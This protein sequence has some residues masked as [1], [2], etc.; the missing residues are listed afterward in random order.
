[1]YRRN[2]YFQKVYPRASRPPSLPRNMTIWNVLVR[3]CCQNAQRLFPGRPIFFLLFFL[4]FSAIKYTVRPQKIPHF[5]ILDSSDEHDVQFALEI[6]SRRSLS[7]F[8]NRRNRIL[9]FSD[10]CFRRIHKILKNGLSM[11]PIGNFGVR[12]KTRCPCVKPP[13]CWTFEFIRIVVI[14][15]NSPHSLLLNFFGFRPQ[16]HDQWLSEKVY[17]VVP[18]PLNFDDDPVSPFAKWYYAWCGN[19]E[20]SPQRIW[21]LYPPSL[22]PVSQ[23]KLTILKS[24][25][26]SPSQPFVHPIS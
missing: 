1:M 10:R 4:R 25:F 17:G 21:S 11:V 22:F 3:T 20:K 2:L 15:A 16:R 7:Y 14:E 9:C 19:I 6:R 23:K 13:Y 12:P 18:W 8:A 24:Y 5:D 26:L